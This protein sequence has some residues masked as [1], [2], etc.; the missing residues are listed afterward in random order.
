MILMTRVLLMGGGVAGLLGGG[1]WTP[2]RLRHSIKP[3]AERSG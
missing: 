1:G 2:S 3:A